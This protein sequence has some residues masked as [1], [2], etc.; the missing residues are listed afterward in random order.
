MNLSVT[1]IVLN[2]NPF[3]SEHVLNRLKKSIQHLYENSDPEISKEVYVINQGSDDAGI[4][5][6]ETLRS[7]YKFNSVCLDDNIG[8][9]GGI[10]FG[11]NI[12][13]GEII[14]LLT[15]DVYMSKGCDTSC[16]NMLKSNPDAYQVIPADSVSD[17]LAQRRNIKIVSNSIIGAEL[18]LCYYRRESIRDVGYYDEKWKA[19]YENLD[20]NLRTVLLGKKILVNHQ[21]HIDHDHNTSNQLIGIERAYTGYISNP[22][23]GGHIT[24]WWNEKW[25]NIDANMGQGCELENKLSPGKISELYDMYKDNIYLGFV[26]NREY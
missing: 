3:N 22:I 8:I 23:G 19:C 17:V 5:E 6:I 9:S 1:Y 7:K 15:Y 25:K 10:N 12:A 13:R 24:R 21:V 26:Q 20:Y 14:A 16:L 18:T 2:W 11:F 4:K